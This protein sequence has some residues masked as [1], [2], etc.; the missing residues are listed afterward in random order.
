M[1]IACFLLSG[2]TFTASYNYAQFAP[3]VQNKL[4]FVVEHDCG[5]NQAVPQQGERG[6]L[7][8]CRAGESETH[9]I[10]R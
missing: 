8:L 1:I 6:V 9:Q 5:H 3:I 4:T 7:N 10:A 2:V